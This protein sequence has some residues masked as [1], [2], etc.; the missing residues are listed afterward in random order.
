MAHSTALLT[1]NVSK[2]P[3][4]WAWRNLHTRQYVNLPWSKTPLRFLFHREVQTGGNNNSLNV[5]G[6]KFYS[7]KD[8][9]VFNSKHVAAYKMVVN[10]DP[11][12][13]WKKDVNLYS[14]DTGMNGHPL[15]GHYFDMNNDHVYGRLSKMKIGQQLEFT[16]IHKLLILPGYVKKEAKQSKRREQKSRLGNKATDFEV[17]DEL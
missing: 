10:F 13:K 8:N 14:I 11:E 6:C 4:D 5:A 16:P 15:Q 12:G 7:N 3:E 9:I 2:R 17:D 1:K